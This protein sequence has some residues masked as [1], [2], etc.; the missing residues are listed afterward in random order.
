MLIERFEIE[1]NNR[2]RPSVQGVLGAVRLSAPVSAARA[3]AEPRSESW[4]CSGTHWVTPSPAAAAASEPGTRPPE[5]HPDG[6]A[7]KH[8]RAHVSLRRFA[9]TTAQL[10]LTINGLLVQATGWDWNFK[11]EA[12]VFFFMLTLN[13][14]E[15][16]TKQ[17]LTLAV[18]K[19]VNL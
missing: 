6:A 2:T 7:Q 13:L 5:L 19:W 4:S 17:M 8:T 3:R 11:Q 12:S 18:P 9:H 15:I 14:Y 16:S 1:V 10:R